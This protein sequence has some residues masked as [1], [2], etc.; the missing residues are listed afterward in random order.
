MFLSELDKE[1]VRSLFLSVII[2]RMYNSRF[3]KF[4]SL[5]Q[6][7][8]IENA[9]A[10]WFDMAIHQSLKVV[11]VTFQNGSIHCHKMACRNSLYRICL[12]MD[13]VKV[14]MMYRDSKNRWLDR[15]DAIL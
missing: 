8:S 7:T 12:S 3:C 13:N 2:G 14:E 9:R 11:Y 5:I 15:E 4:S 6:V 1:E 10:L